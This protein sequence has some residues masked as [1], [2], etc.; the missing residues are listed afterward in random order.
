MRHVR[1]AVLVLLLACIPSAAQMT[2]TIGGA[3][4]PPGT[5]VIIQETDGSPTG[6]F[7]TLKVS[8]GSLTNNG[9]G[10]A[11]VVTGAPALGY[12]PEDAANKKTDATLGTSN[13]FYP[14][15]GAVKA[16]VDSGVKAM[17][18]TALTPRPCIGANTATITLNADNL[19]GCDYIQVAELSQPTTF[20]LSTVPT[21]TY[22]Q[23][24]FFS[25]RIFT[26]TQRALT[27]TTGAGKFA[28]EGIALPTFSR[29]GGYVLY[30]FSYNALSNRWAFAS[31]N[32]T[33]N[34]G[35]A[36]FVQTAGGPG[37]EPD[38]QA[39]AGGL[40]G[41]I[42][43]I[44]LPMS[45]A[46]FPP[47]NPAVFDGSEVN[48]RLRFDGGAISECVWW[49]PFR[50][51]SDY[52]STPVFKFLYSMTSATAGGV[53]INVSVIT[54]APS[55]DNVKTKPFTTVNNCDDTT[56]PAELGDYKEISCPLV[57]NDGMAPNRWTK[58]QLCRLTSDGA[59]TAELSDMEGLAASLE[60]VR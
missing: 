23:G 52:A 55:G 38:W 29:A 59:D 31:T 32:Q 57:N 2:A 6:S 27:F 22:V 19:T 9:D 40:T 60:Y 56:V 12:T 37:V 17:A 46:Q 1:W 28:A 15:Q 48:G 54:A 18:N 44:H 58:L 39:P 4:V 34:Y 36:G 10:S 25:L 33:T 45:A 11:T 3:P 20:D 47:V 26:T 14:T 8:P 49:G 53:S 30:G 5:S 21:P 42:G 16:Y 35:A 41:S 7:T 43:T 50:M 51:N 24:Q 13:D